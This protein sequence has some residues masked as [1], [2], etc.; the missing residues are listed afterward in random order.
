[1]SMRFPTGSLLGPGSLPKASRL[2]GPGMMEA[3]VSPA[4]PTWGIS[5]KEIEATAPHFEYPRRCAPPSGISIDQCGS[6]AF[7]ICINL[8]RRSRQAMKG[9]KRGGRWAVACR[10]TLSRLCG[11]QSF[12]KIG[13]LFKRLGDDAIFVHRS[14][15]RNIVRLYHGWRGCKHAL[16]LSDWPRPAPAFDHIVCSWFAFPK[17]N[18]ISYW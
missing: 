9:V 16:W 14:G 7:A 10:A 18:H 13:F 2:A 3:A 4:A 8:Q 5:R 6:C 17:S 12:E 11:R 1:M 15:K